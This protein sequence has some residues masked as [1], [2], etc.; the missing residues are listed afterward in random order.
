VWRSASTSTP[1]SSGSGSNGFG[2]VFGNPAGGGSGSGG[3][4]SSGSTG[5]SD[6]K[7]IAAKVAPALV[8]IDTDLSYQDDEAA[9][10]G[11]VVT[12]SGE[13]LTNNHVIAEATQI[14][15][16]DVG[17][18]HKYAAR[19]IGYDRT[20]DIAVLQIEGAA[21]LTTASLGDSSTVS[22]GNQIVGIGNAGGT[23]GQPTSVGGIV[24][25]LDQSITATDESDGSSEQL[26]GLIQV[27]A[28][29]KPGDSGGS[30]V[31]TKG[32]V[33]G[34][35]TAASAGFSFQTSGGQGF[36]IPIDQALSIAR[37][38][39]VGRSTG[40]IH[41]GATA[42][43]GVLVDPNSAIGSGAT[44]ANAVP[45]EPAAEAGLT[46][47]DTITS[48]AGQ[49]VGSPAALT[50][51]ILRYHPGDKVQVNWVDASGQSHQA[52]ITLAPG[53]PQ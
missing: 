36:A 15:V 28:D 40:G 38:I 43:L 47:G 46:K 23:G 20:H 29:I 32:Q 1:Q 41:I 19:V 31:N 53:P 9:G 8:D 6:I 17:N 49:S 3:S 25:A 35:D 48:L 34:I 45:G 14:S 51:L 33:V 50:T 18:G 22:V 26:A 7:S 11:I 5:P 42:F 44:L 37:Q 13:V 21:N 10:T 27:N 52:T 30:L 12:P 24:S 2:N 4:G 16:T 39:E